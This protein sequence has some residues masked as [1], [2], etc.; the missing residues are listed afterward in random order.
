[1]TGGPASGQAMAAV[2]ATATGPGQGAVGHGHVG[3][4]GG[5]HIAFGGQHRTP[6]RTGSQANPEPWVT[7]SLNAGW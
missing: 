7:A 1:M 3:H 2:R 6:G 4:G 5:T